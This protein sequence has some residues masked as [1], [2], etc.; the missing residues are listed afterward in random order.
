MILQVLADRFP[1]FHPR[2]D[3]YGWSDPSNEY[4]GDEEGG[5]PHWLA[6]VNRLTGIKFR[7]TATNNPH[8]R[9]E[10]VRGPLTRLVDGKPAFELCPSCKMIRKG[11][12][13]GYHYRRI[14]VGGASGRFD[15]KPEKNIYSHVCE[16]LEYLL[17]GGGHGV[18]GVMGIERGAGRTMM[19]ADS[20]YDIF[21]D[22]A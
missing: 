21:G 6:K 20:D 19:I 7:P 3:T 13:S 12:N 1:G 17:L 16:S 4:G 15:V 14:R 10:A 9:Q 2:N 18:A 11:L 8:M 22:A 5:D